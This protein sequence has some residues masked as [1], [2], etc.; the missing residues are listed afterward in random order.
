MHPAEINAALDGMVYLIDTREQPTPSLQARLRFFG[1][2]ERCKLD[3]GDYSA[4][5]PLPDGTWKT[6]QAA[7]ERKMDFDEL[8]NCYCKGRARF[9]R[10]FERAKEA[11][12]KLYLLIE[13][14]SWEDAYHGAYRS[15]MAPKSLIASMLA[16]LAR[17]DC[18]VLFCQSYT[19]GQLIRDVLYREAKEMLT[20]MVDDG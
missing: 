10:E 5:V 16:W 15:H 11:N 6:V 20:R 2:H 13:G 14:G 12:I 7:V 17:Y 9:T 4:K 8:A 1:K 3:A 19:T 18:Q